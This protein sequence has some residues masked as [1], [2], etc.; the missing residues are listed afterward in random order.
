MVVGIS[1]KITELAKNYYKTPNIETIY[2][3]IKLIDPPQCDPLYDFVCVARFFPVKNHLFL[4]NVFKEFVDKHSN[5]KLVLVGGGPL[6]DECRKLVK[7]LHLDSN[8]LFTGPI[9][10]VYDYLAKS[11]A[12]ILPSLYEGNPISIL[13]AMNCGLP[14]IA[15]NVGGVSDVVTSG[16]NGFLFEKNNKEELLFCLNQLYNN[17]EIKRLFKKNNVLKIKRY[18]IEYCCKQYLSL[19]IKNIHEKTLTRKHNI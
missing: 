12:F 16:E 7:E 15:S 13:E 9:D 14:I 18:N 10:K 2:N 3:G 6:L 1:D 5:C 11:T 8:I 4:I 19:C 17:D